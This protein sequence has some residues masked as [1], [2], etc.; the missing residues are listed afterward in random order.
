MTTKFNQD[1]Y[2]KIRSKKNEPL[3]NLE[4]RTVCVIEKGFFVNPVAPDT[5]IIRKASPATS[6]E[7]ITPIWKKPRVAN[8]GKEKVDSLLSS[9]WDN[10]GL[11]MARAHEVIT[12]KELKVFFGMPP[13]EVVG[14]H[15]HKLIQ[16]TYLCNFTLFF[17][18]FLYCPE[19]FNFLFKC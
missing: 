1:M 7:E 9:V 13:N 10:T 5:K 3:S 19:N 14:R 11:A 18:F 6:V 12:T 15:I 2:A 4:K 17:L 8:K 16:V